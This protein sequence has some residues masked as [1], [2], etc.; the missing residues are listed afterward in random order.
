MF[1]RFLSFP[2]SIHAPL[3]G[4]DGDGQYLILDWLIS[5]HAPLAGSDL[6]YILDTFYYPVFLSTLPSR[7][8]T[9]L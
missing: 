5:I 6:E 9:A 1:F 7:G 8:A 4:S 3:A 2:I